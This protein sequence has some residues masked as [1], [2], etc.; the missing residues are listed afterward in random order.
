MSVPT[1]SNRR[2]PKID[3]NCGR[4]GLSV[5]IARLLL[6]EQGNLAKNGTR[7]VCVYRRRN[8]SLPRIT[9]SSK[10]VFSPMK[11]LLLPSDA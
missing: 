4:S 10:P 7:P 6:S 2:F 1:S 9:Q 8:F 11:M 3:S 5:Q